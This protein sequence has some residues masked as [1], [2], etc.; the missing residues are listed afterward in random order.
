MGTCGLKAK[1]MDD[2]ELSIFWKLFE[3]LHTQKLKR[4]NVGIHFE[5]VG[6]I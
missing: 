6:R 3:N 4:K 1:Q 2:K 5:I